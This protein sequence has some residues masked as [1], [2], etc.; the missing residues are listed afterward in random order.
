MAGMSADPAVHLSAAAVVIHA[1]IGRYALPACVSHAMAV[2]STDLAV[3]STDPAVVIAAA[4]VVIHARSV[5]P[6]S[7]R[8]SRTPRRW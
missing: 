8:A 7:R 6:Q 4:A 3:V 1:R 2:V 5:E